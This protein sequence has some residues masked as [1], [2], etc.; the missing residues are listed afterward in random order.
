MSLLRLAAPWL[1][2]LATTTAHGQAQAPA[3]SPKPTPPKTFDLPAIDAYLSAWKL[4]GAVPGLSVAIVRDGKIVLAK[5]YGKQAIGGDPVGPDTAFSIG[6]VTKQF[7]CAAA[8]LLAE[9]GKLSLDDPV[10][11]YLPDLTRAGDIQVRRLMNHTSGYPD[12]YPL[13]FVDRRMTKATTADEILANY[14]KGKL[15]FEP[16]ARWSYTNTAYIALGRIIEKV[17][18]MPLGTFLEQRIFGPVGMKRSAL[19]PAQ[20]TTQGHRSFAIGPA[21]PAPLERPVW[22]FSAGG[23]WAS[24]EDVARWDL[25]LIDG[26]L[27]QAQSFREMT[28]PTPLLDGRVK[29]YGLGLGILRREGEIVYSHG[30]SVSG[31]KAYNGFIPRTRSALVVL[32]NGEGDEASEIYKALLGLVLKDGKPTDAPRV[33]GPKP[34]VVARE[35]FHQMRTGK[36]DRSKLGDEFSTYLT[37]EK[38]A[39]AAERFQKLGEPKSVETLDVGER[40]GME[41]ATVEIHF[42][43]ETL[44]GLLYRS[45][46]GK[47]QQL[48][49][50]K[51]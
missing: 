25:A 47:I 41:V 38:L 9:E 18:G 26:K 4:D 33:D 6:S 45:P 30:G 39:G 5:G 29:D 16:G 50:R 17:S 2:L 10:A 19:D 8:L 48:L 49:F 44:E 22:L 40:G 51:P 34:E 3:D 20:P 28:A 32:T 14:A 11:R 36:V 12:Y 27:L 13:D 31:F 21:E 43:K 24:A 37:D 42:E 23:T 15:D 7:I 35:F 46:D 1:V